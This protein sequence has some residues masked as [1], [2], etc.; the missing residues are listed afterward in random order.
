LANEQFQEAL[1]RAP[2]RILSLKGQFTALNKL[3]DKSKAEEIQNKLN[4]I[5]KSSEQQAASL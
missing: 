4:L 3:G 5:L 2:N 1:K